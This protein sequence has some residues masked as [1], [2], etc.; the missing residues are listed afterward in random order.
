MVTKNSSKTGKLLPSKKFKK[1][2]GKGRDNLK[3]NL[4]R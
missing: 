3:P 4:E 2:S 1:K